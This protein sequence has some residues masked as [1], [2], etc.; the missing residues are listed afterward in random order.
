MKV[1]NIW[2]GPGIG[3]STTAADLFVNMKKR[4]LNV[5]LVTEYAKD[6]VWERRHNLFEDQI[7][8]FA[9]QHR[10]IQRLE[11]HGIDW[12]ITDSPIPLGLVYLNDDLAYAKSLR[13]L[14][15]D[16]FALFNNSNYLLSRYFGYNPVGRNQ[17]D[18][19]E[20][21]IFDNRVKALLDEWNVPF[22]TVQ[23]GNTAVDYIINEH[24]DKSA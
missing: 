17:K 12:V 5:E 24:L 7:Y 13:N 18:E 10:R 19:M 3:K 20:A 1:I 8:I 21:I 11:G 4:Q 22:T 2:G 15:K 16:T 23:A 6:A 14:I 9:K